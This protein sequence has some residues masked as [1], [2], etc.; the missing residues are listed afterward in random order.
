MHNNE[1]MFCQYLTNHTEDY[2]I[3]PAAIYIKSRS[4]VLLWDVL[5]MHSVLSHVTCLIMPHI[6][7][8]MPAFLLASISLFILRAFLL[9]VSRSV[10]VRCI[11]VSACLKAGRYR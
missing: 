10:A 6:S 9:L 2:A 5:H 8:L 7:C 1:W 3:L 11:A 4:H